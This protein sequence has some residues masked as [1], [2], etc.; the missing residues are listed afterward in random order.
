[1]WFWEMKFVLTKNE[2]KKDIKGKKTPKNIKHVFCKLDFCFK[3][4]RK[5]KK[6][7]NEV[8]NRNCYMCIRSLRR[9]K[10]TEF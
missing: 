3:L 6:N 2:K 4:K 8:T 7:R 9:Y 1:M 5:R 10:A